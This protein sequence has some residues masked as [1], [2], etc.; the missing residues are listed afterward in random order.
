M[1]SITSFFSSFLPTI[2]ADAPAEEKPAQQET[3]A[4]S[5]EATEEPAGEVKEEEK[6][7]PRWD[8]A[9]DLGCGPGA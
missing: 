9:V 6:A 4:K 1:S 7:E 3:E 8:V 5:E 2:Q